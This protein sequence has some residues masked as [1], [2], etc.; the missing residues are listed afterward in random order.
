MR[1]RDKVVA[2]PPND[3]PCQGRSPDSELEVDA[4]VDDFEWLETGVGKHPLNARYAASPLLD[5]AHVAASERES[6][7]AGTGMTFLPRKRLPSRS[8]FLPPK[9]EA[10]RTN[11]RVI[12]S[13]TM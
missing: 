11:G 3:H 7:V 4:V 5:D 9:I 2:Q 1:R 12:T 13:T 6:L 8:Y 10:M